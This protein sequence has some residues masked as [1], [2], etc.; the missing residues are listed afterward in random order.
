MKVLAP[1]RKSPE[2]LTR[3]T[4]GLINAVARLTNVLFGVCSDEEAEFFYKNIQNLRDSNKKSL[5][6]AHEQLRIV[7]S[8]VQ[9]VNF[10]IHD[11]TTDY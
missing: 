8:V 7:S 4:R 3:R 5:H 9:D 11:L 6:L 10:T 2:H 1:G